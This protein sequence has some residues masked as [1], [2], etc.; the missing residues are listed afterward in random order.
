MAYPRLRKAGK[1]L[2]SADVNFVDLSE[3]FYDKNFVAYNDSCCHYAKEANELF[4]GNVSRDIVRLL[5][6]E[7]KAN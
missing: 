3:L 6:I 7:A 2:R 4:A 1:D 5:K